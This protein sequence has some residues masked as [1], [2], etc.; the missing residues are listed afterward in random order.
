MT[1]WYWALG[2]EVA[3]ICLIAWLMWIA[4]EMNHE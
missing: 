1:L 4:P 3:A 2:L